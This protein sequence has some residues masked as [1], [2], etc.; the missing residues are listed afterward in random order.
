MI[1]L[2]KDGLL[3]FT[4][5]MLIIGGADA[6]STVKEQDIQINLT[7]IMIDDPTGNALNLGRVYLGYENLIPA[8]EYNILGNDILVPHPGYSDLIFFAMGLII[9]WLMLHIFTT[10][11]GRFLLDLVVLTLVI[12]ASYVVSKLFFYYVVFK[13]ALINLG[14][15]EDFAINIIRSVSEQTQG[16]H[17]ASLITMSIIL[18]AVMLNIWK[19]LKQY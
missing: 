7:E 17:L 10:L 2:L 1:N 16:F 4:A 9:F 6:Y 19:M 8:A 12:G 3:I 18:I 14:F 5:I 15:P 13:P 11:T